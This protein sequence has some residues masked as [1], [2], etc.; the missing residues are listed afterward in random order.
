MIPRTWLPGRIVALLIGKE[1][2]ADVNTK[3]V[4]CQPSTESGTGS[5]PSVATDGVDLRPRAVRVVMSRG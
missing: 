1:L 3:R 5:T 2:I 4:I